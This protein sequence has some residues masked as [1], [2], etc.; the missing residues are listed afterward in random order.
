MK[1]S[2]V[3][4]SITLSQGMLES[5]FGNS[6]LAIEANNHFGIKCH[7]DWTGKTM[8]RDDDRPNE[9][10]RS[11][12]SVLESYTD[13]SN[14]LRERSRYE[15]LFELKSTDYKGW[16]YGLKKAG[17]AT[18][19]NYPKRLIKLIEDYELYKYD[20]ELDEKDLRT[21][22][23]FVKVSV[24]KNIDGFVIDIEDRHEVKYNNGVKYIEVEEGD[25]F[26]LISEEFGMRPWEIYT[27]NDLDANASVKKYRYLYIQPKKGRANRSYSFHILKHSETLHYLS[28][29][30]G[31]KLRKIYKFNNFEK[32]Y[33]PT[34]GT[35]IYL[36]KKH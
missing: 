1:R 11:Y 7:N 35:K 19:P 5:N 24:R 9:C 26:E 12:K 15:F 13:H 16:S 3:P 29:K 20:I 34:A 22:D 8:H 33:E 10:F 18:D 31:V 14:F 23:D 27:Y 6:K 21:N 36:R 4:A 28:Q 25:S 32:G 30:Y 2:G 17:Y